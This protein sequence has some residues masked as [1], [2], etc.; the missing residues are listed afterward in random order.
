MPGTP[1][2]VLNPV[3]DACRREVDRVRGSMWHG[4]HS[5]CTECFSQWYDPDN[6]TFDS[7]N[8]VSLGNYVRKKHGL[9][10]LPTPQES[11]SE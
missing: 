10:P 4:Q 5:I 1:S 3:C 7:N 8:P 11:S 2:S 9:P 6:G